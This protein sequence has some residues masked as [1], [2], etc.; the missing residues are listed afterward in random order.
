MIEIRTTPTILPKGALA[1][2]NYPTININVKDSGITILKQARLP[3]PN[4]S[5]ASVFRKWTHYCYS[6]NFF[7]NE[8]QVA[9]NGRALK[10]IK[11]SANLSCQL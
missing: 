5:H 3:I 9:Y 1:S 7:K 6:F 11:K 2:E 8:A 10:K 4:W